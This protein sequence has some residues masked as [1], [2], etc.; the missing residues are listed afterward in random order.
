MDHLRLSHADDEI[1]IV[2]EAAAAEPVV[3][4]QGDRQ[5]VVAYS[6]S[7]AQGGVSSHRPKFLIQETQRVLVRTWVEGLNAQVFGAALR[8]ESSGMTLDV[9][10][11]GGEF[12]LVPGYWAVSSLRGRW[13]S[14]SNG[15]WIAGGIFASVTYQ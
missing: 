9:P 3:M 1:I 2:V 7:D 5:S 15:H 11:A 13:T 8:Q 10:A 4:P 6:K 14:W 12:D